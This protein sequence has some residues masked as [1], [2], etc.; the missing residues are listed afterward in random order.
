MRKIIVGSSGAV[1]GVCVTLSIITAMI[2]DKYGCVMYFLFA[3]V[4]IMI[5]FGCVKYDE[6]NYDE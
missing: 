3:I 2:G 6:D 5:G 1:A 4:A